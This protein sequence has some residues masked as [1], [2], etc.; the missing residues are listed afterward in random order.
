MA[1]H[2]KKKRQ[3]KSAGAKIIRPKNKEELEA[4]FWLYEEPGLA[5]FDVRCFTSG[6]IDRNVL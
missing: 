4:G 2:K 6:V 5:V 3:K 1:K